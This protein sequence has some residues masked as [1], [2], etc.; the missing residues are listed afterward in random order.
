MMQMGP[1]AREIQGYRAWT[2]AMRAP[3][4]LPAPLDTLCSYP[5]GRQLIR[6]SQN[7]HRKKYFMVRVNPIGRKALMGRGKPAFPVGSVIVKEK[8]L[9][10]A[11]NS[12]ELLTV[13]VKREKGYHP[14]GGDW[15]YLALNG[16]GT[17]VDGRGRLESCRSCHVMNRNSDFVFR[18]YMAFTKPERSP[19]ERVA[20]PRRPKVTPRTATDAPPR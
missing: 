6:T 8:L 10:K 5:V 1:A 15:E 9:S 19:F 4:V 18:T 13:M 11:A 20:A 3:M 16:A 7:P 14:S 2:Q 12:P 17:R